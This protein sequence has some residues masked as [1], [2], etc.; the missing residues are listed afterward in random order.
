MVGTINVA[1]S[2]NSANVK[3]VSILKSNLG[4]A[5][6]VI[7][8]F[9]LLHDLVHLLTCTLLEVINIK[10]LQWVGNINCT[11]KNKFLLPIHVHKQLL[12]VL[13]LWIKSKDRVKVLDY[14]FELR[15]W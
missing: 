12:Q 7:A 6:I 2:L 9:E 11:C 1:N 14:D 4:I 8:H 13:S 3:L 5:H 10:H 15:F